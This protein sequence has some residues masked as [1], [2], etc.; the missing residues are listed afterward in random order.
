MRSLACSGVLLEFRIGGRPPSRTQ[1]S[2]S[3]GFVALASINDKRP[4]GEGER[5]GAGSEA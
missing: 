2:N 5:V 3:L 1:E 4:K